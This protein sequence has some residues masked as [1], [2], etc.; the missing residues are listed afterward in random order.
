MVELNTISNSNGRLINGE[1]SFEF[2]PSYTIK[3][4]E[5]QTLA[6][7]AKLDPMASIGS[8]F[9]LN[10]DEIV[11][12]QGTVNIETVTRKMCYLGEAPEN[13]TI[14]GAFADWIKIPPFTDFDGNKISNKNVNLQ[15]CRCFIDKNSSYF[16]WACFS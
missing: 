9:G 1:V 16:S 3:K 14:D 12:S 7:F 6:I 8:S 15:D 10:L 13:I 2:D 5:K 11:I 4:N